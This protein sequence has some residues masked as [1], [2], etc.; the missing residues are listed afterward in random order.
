MSQI[1]PA[2]TYADPVIVDETTNKASFNPIWL[3]WFLDLAAVISGAGGAGG[4]IDHTL[5]GS[6]N[7]A[8]YT[9]LSATNATDLTDAGETTL[10]YHTVAP[11]F[12]VGGGT[13]RGTFDVTD[14]T[15]NT[16]PAAG[17]VNQAVITGPNHATTGF[18]PIQGQLT[19]QSNTAF[20]LNAGQH[21]GAT[22][23]LGGL[24]TTGSTD[25]ANFAAISGRKHYA[26][27]GL[28]DGY[29]E[30]STYNST[31]G[32]RAGLTINK[33]TNAT[34]AGT[35]NINGSTTGTSFNGSSLLL[36]GDAVVKGKIQVG[37]YTTV[38]VYLTGADLCGNPWLSGSEFYY[39]NRYG[40]QGGITEYRSLIVGDGK[41]NTLLT[42][43]GSATPSLVWGAGVFSVGPTG[44]I[45]SGTV[46]ALTLGQLSTGFSIAGGTS[47]S[48]LQITGSATVAVANLATGF[49]IEG[50]TIAKTLTVPDTAS[51]SGTNTGDVAFGGMPDVMAFAAA[52]G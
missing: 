10:H 29:L 6:L 3:K 23:A 31:W 44:N 37:D 1:N 30:L 41:G 46:N 36:S 47:P 26:N 43:N 52:Q 35:L 21:V 24:T 20:A 51:V 5:L 34:F 15:A 27:D 18:Q 19:V 39:I 16:T 45:I 49:S 17:P 4:S 12:A 38:G 33:D 25:A 50:G 48:T 22:I 42:V 7:S 2:P 8:S 28:A 32:W 13:R 9:H 11:T 40:Y 14:G